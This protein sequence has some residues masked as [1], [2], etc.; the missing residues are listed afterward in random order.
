MKVNLLFRV[1]PKKQAQIAEFIDDNALESHTIEVC[2]LVKVEQKY[3]G[4]VSTFLESQGV[5]IIRSYEE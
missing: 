4:A 2:Q 1:P 3:A 5:Q